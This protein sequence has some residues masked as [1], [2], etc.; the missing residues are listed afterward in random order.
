M[1]EETILGGGEAANEDATLATEEIK[2]EVLK[3][4]PKQEAGKKE[5][6]G[7][8]KKDT[9]SQ[10][11]TSESAPESYTDFTFPEGTEVNADA[12]AEAS[13]LF[14]EMDLSQAQAQKLVDLQ[15]KMQQSEMGK[16]QEAWVKMTEDWKKESKID[17]EFGG[18][19]LNESLTKMKLAIN[20]FG[21][22]KFK[23]MLEITGVGNHPEMLRFLVNTGKIVSD[24]AIL[25]GSNE[26]GASKDAAK[27]M[28][29]KMN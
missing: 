28:F 27:I 25:S 9:D 12:V 6:D 8:A 10:A 18:A 14:K 19:L 7:E 17:K 24:D 21:N 13:T 1:A 22:D 4:E 15:S 5:E 26:S 3:E 23:E 29:P 16:T 2:E 11:D 20:A